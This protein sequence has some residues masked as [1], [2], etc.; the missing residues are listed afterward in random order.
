MYAYCYNDPVNKVDY[1]GTAP[2]DLFS[3]PDE[4][5]IDFANYINEKSIAENREYASFI[6]AIKVNRIIQYQIPTCVLPSILLFL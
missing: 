6:Y 2:G 3:T 1:C 5:A 4:A